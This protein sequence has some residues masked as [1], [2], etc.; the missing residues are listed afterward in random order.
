MI[1][2]ILSY[3]IK[4]NMRK[5]NHSNTILHLPSIEYVWVIRRNIY[6]Y[7]F[8]CVS[9]SVYVSVCEED[10][11]EK[12]DKRLK[13]RV[14][15]RRGKRKKKREKLIHTDKQIDGRIDRLTDRHKSFIDMRYNTEL[16]SKS[17]SIESNQFEIK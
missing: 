10:V 3:L 2:I 13:K 6:S 14:K 16:Y 17:N 8:V 12:R 7:E 4:S 5:Y 1:I 11:H 9:V 15:K